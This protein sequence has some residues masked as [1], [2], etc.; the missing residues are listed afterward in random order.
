MPMNCNEMA[1]YHWNKIFHLNWWG[2]SVYF[3][4][5]LIFTCF[6]DE[7]QN[8][9]FTK[10]KNV[11]DLAQSN[12]LVEHCKLQLYLARFGCGA[13]SAFTS[14]CHSSVNQNK[15]WLFWYLGMY[16]PG[17][18]NKILG[19]LIFSLV[20]YRSVGIE[21]LI[22]FWNNSLWYVW[23]IRSMDSNGKVLTCQ[24]NSPPLESCSTVC[25]T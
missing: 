22:P 18:G 12:I 4:E 21:P 20:M 17:S 5:V 6:E 1:W 9:E 7:G 11:S 23:T 2:F 24:K 15:I 19:F 10:R 16:G 14:V 25:F 13:G 3:K 8:F